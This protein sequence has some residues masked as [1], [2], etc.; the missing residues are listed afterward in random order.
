MVK[1]VCVVAGDAKGN[2]YFEQVSTNVKIFLDYKHLRDRTPFS[3]CLS[4]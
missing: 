3:M 1:A 2:I 4:V